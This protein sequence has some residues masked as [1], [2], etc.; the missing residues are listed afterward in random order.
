MKSEAGFV[1]SKVGLIFLDRF[2]NMSTPPL[3]G[4]NAGM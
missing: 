2:N 3:N 4:T 1:C